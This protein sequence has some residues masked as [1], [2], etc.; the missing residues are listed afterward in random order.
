[1]AHKNHCS[2][3]GW[4]FLFLLTVITYLYTFVLKNTIKSMYKD[5]YNVYL[6]I[7]AFYFQFNQMNLSN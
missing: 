3:L 2:H 6:S 5:C 4:Y 1:M 7:I